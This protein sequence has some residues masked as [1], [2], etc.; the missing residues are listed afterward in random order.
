[1]T[2]V[3]RGRRPERRA[4]IT[5]GNAMTA[6]PAVVPQPSQPIAASLMVVLVATGGTSHE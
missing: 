5:T 6:T 3:G 1:M 2:I 4:A